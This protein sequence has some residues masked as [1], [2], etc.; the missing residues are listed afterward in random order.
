MRPM[1]PGHAAAGV[2]AARCH[3]HE[4]SSPQP[5]R[6][7]DRRHPQARASPRGSRRAIRRG[8]NSNSPTSPRTSSIEP[9]PAKRSQL[10][11]DPRPPKVVVA[12]ALCLDSQHGTILPPVS[13]ISDNP[14][15]QG[16]T[17]RR[18]CLRGTY[19]D[20]SHNGG[21]PGTPEAAARGPGDRRP[22]VQRC[23]GKRRDRRH[24]PVSSPGECCS[25]AHAARVSP[26]QPGGLRTRGSDPEALR[27]GCGGARPATSPESSKDTHRVAPSVV[28]RQG[29]HALEA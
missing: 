8:S 2:P 20:G 22:G 11:A 24:L 9:H 26:G 5:R 27:R 4:W 7:V 25:P 12:G 6:R 23:G 28:A 15:G 10:S 13:I 18:V 19:S 17:S 21:T 16:E 14:I 3:S 29:Q 1:P